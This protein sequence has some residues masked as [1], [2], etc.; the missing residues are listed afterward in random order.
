MAQLKKSNF[1]LGFDT[2]TQFAYQTSTHVGKF[3]DS[4]KSIVVAPYGTTHSSVQ[5]GRDAENKT[6]DYVMR[7]KNMTPDRSV[8]DTYNEIRVR[9]KRDSTVIG[10]PNSTI[11][12]GT[13]MK[14]SITP[15]H[16]A[17]K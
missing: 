16:E 10:V 13:T 4:P 14:D 5:M 3:A 15:K 2:Q 9:M 8:S 12:T 6:S 7:F 17:S 1:S 11:A